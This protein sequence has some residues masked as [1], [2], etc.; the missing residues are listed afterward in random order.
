MCNLGRPF[1]TSLP[2]VGVCGVEKP[3]CTAIALSMARETLQA[4]AIEWL[5]PSL[6]VDRPQRASHT[7]GR[8]SEA[9][10]AFGPGS[11][12]EYHCAAGLLDLVPLSL[13]S[14]AQARATAMEPRAK[15]PPLQA[16][17]TTSG[18]GHRQRHLNDVTSHRLY[19]F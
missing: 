13:S 16:K 17:A 1:R 9:S 18:T 12:D 3:S 2:S 5:T 14:H 19:R 7:V 15:T 4:V 11:I 10:A 8:H 6:Y